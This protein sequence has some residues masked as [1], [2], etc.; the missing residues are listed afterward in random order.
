MT[1]QSVWVLRYLK[2]VSIVTGN[3][4]RR[5]CFCYRGGSVSHSVL[6]DVLV[7]R[8]ALNIPLAVTSDTA[9]NYFHRVMY[10]HPTTCMMISLHVA[11]R[12][13]LTQLADGGDAFQLWRAAANIENAIA[14]CRQ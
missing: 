1:A 3:C 13:Q 6:N 10:D 5:S 9:M 4:A 2:T 12:T 8:T 11:V 14:D 7:F